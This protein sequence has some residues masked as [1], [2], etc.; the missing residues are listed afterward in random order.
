MR[1]GGIRY[2]KAGEHHIAF[3]E[4]VGDDR[5]GQEIVMVNGGFWPMDTL[6]D[7]P[8]ANRSSRAWLGSVA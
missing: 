4:L 8:I 7:D 5:G 2:A 3:R 1:L 6:P